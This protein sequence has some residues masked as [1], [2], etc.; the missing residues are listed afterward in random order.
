ML[1]QTPLNRFPLWYI[2]KMTDPRDCDLWNQ[3]FQSS[4]LVTLAFLRPWYL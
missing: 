3:A 2:L 4:Y 1:M